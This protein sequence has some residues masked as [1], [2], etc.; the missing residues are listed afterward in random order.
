[1]V[2]LGVTGRARCAVASLRRE[3][4]L[5]GIAPCV[6]RLFRVHVACGAAD[7]ASGPEVVP[8]GLARLWI[9]CPDM[10]VR[11]ALGVGRVV[12]L[13]V[14]GSVARGAGSIARGSARPGVAA[15]TP[16]NEGRAQ[17][18]ARSIGVQVT[19]FVQQIG[20]CSLKPAQDD[21]L[22]PDQR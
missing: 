13:L 9:H 2:S 3:P 12:P 14:Y 17:L 8:L 4:E 10:Q 5:A 19:E 1:M 20:A 7:T 16:V 11:E 21:L 18:G 15:Q 6:S 22:P